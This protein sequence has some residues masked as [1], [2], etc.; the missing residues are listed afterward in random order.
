MSGRHNI[1]RYAQVDVLLVIHE[2]GA[3]TFT[4][5]CLSAISLKRYMNQLYTP[6][7]LLYS[8]SERMEPSK[9]PNDV[10]SHVAAVG[11]EM[12]QPHVRS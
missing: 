9:V 6:S 1:D 11:C 2:G 12:L 7:V 5:P 8:I 4:F 3:D 10:L